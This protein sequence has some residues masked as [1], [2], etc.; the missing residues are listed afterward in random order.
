MYYFS[1]ISNNLSFKN[2]LER[3]VFNFLKTKERTSVHENDLE[4]FKKAIVNGINELNAT[5]KRCTPI[6]PDFWQP[7]LTYKEDEDHDIHL[8]VGGF[9]SFHLYSSN[10]K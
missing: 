3:D 5:H 7:S 8:H 10:N 6:K 4:D 1:H 9:V 2:K